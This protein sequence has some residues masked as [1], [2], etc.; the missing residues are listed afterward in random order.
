MENMNAFS[1]NPAFLGFDLIYIGILA[2]F[3]M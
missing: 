3:L 1:R 2:I